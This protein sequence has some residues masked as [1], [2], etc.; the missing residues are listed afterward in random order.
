MYP[1]VPGTAGSQGGCAAR[2][3][4][5]ATPTNS[6]VLAI[7]IHRTAPL[8]SLREAKVAAPTRC[9]GNQGLAG[10]LIGDPYGALQNLGR[11]QNRTRPVGVANLATRC[12]EAAGQWRTGIVLF[13]LLYVLKSNLSY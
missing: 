4:K 1:S 12:G 13:I 7:S 2:V 3:A 5:L 8:R 9:S 10:R 11:L 6:E